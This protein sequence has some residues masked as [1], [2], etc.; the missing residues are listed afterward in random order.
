MKKTNLI[1]IITIGLLIIISVVI[2]F[3]RNID[4]Q[5]TLRDFAVED[6]AS[7]NKI[8]LANKAGNSVLLE[9]TG[10][11]WIANG[12]YVARR[13]LIDNILTTIKKVEVSAPVA[14]SKLERV[15]RDLS[16]Q[17]IKVEIYQNDKK[18]KAYYV[19]G[20]TEDNNGAYMIIEDSDLPFIV[21]R[22][23]FV[24]YL[25]V[26]YLPEI[27]EWRER[28]AFRYHV[29]QM[30]KVS[31]EY[32]DNNY[33]FCAERLGEN[34]YKLRNIDNSDVN[35]NYDEQRVKEFFGRIKFIGFETYLLDS[36][37]DFK[38]DSL[39][40]TEMLASF[41]IEDVDGNINQFTTYRRPNISGLMQSDSTP[42]PYD[43]DNLYGILNGK[44]VVIM[45][46]PT[47]DP[48]TFNKYDFKIGE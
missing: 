4:P 35:F 19:G 10:N 38:R 41:K 46:Y 42:Y 9:R 43:P 30:K 31:V 17:G 13:D 26:H 1:L 48:I 18:V 33:S 5:H 8:F 6:T 45:Q 15:M 20:V 34:S 39:Q 3:T 37:Q 27:N 7:I 36:I 47:I 2:Y 40:H 25:T 32:P 16:V 22:P 23:G 28:I 14:K 12:K 11:G 21:S 44:D 24:G 29:E